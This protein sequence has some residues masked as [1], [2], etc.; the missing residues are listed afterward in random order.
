MPKRSVAEDSLGY[1][2]LNKKEVSIELKK[3]K[4]IFSKL[5]NKKKIFASIGNI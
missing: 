5:T 2:I 3:Y 1:E 4:I